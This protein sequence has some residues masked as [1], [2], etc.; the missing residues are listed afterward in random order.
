MTM[1]PHDLRRRATSRAVEVFCAA[2]VVL[3]LIPLGLV[4]FFAMPRTG[5]DAL[6]GLLFGSEQ[7]QTGYTPELN[8]DAEGP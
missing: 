5:A 6:S 3:A 4:L 8:L 1:T 2:S 7:A